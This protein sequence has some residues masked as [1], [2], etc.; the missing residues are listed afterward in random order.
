MAI[1]HHQQVLHSQLTIY[2]AGRIWQLVAANSDAISLP[3]EHSHQGWLQRRVQQ[4]QHKGLHRM[5]VVSNK[6][7]DWA[8]GLRCGH[9]IM[10]LHLH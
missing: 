4:T 3:E 10:R 6:L 8:T 2:S 1:G 7:L 5:E 9:P